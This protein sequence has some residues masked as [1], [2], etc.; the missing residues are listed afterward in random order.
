MYLDK[1]TQGGCE[2]GTRLC[3]DDCL[4][5]DKQ[6]GGECYGGT[7][8]CG[9]SDCTGAIGP[10][11]STEYTHK[12]CTINGEKTCIPREASCG[13]EDCPTGTKL[14]GTDKCLLPWQERFY[15]ECDGKCLTIRKEFT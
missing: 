2:V 14:C 6:C 4:V 10:Y 11:G 3:G 5:Y 8:T 15:Y 7:V 9:E 12:T 1:G 13:D